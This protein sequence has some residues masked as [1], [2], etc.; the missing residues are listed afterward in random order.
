L[1]VDPDS[2]ENKPLAVAWICVLV[3]HS[4]WDGGRG[5]GGRGGDKGAGAGRR[6]VSHSKYHW[7]RVGVLHVEYLKKAINAKKPLQKL[8]AEGAYG[9]V[10]EVNWT[11]GSLCPWNWLV[12]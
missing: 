1:S 11:M 2:S 8:S 5:G 3:S 4:G 7:R 12:L 10:P 6:E 9:C